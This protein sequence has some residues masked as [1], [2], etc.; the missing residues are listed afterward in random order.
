MMTMIHSISNI[1]YEII[2][3]V[4]GVV[5]AEEIVIFGSAATGQMNPDS[6]IDIAVIVNSANSKRHIAM[7]IYLALRGIGVPIDIIVITPEEIKKYKDAIGTI[8][9]EI[10]Y[11]G[12]TIYKFSGM[13][14]AS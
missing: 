11:N 5:K 10:I 8:I 12:R 1:L 3:R 2:D 6:D 14:K 4:L 9:P 13:A 7:D